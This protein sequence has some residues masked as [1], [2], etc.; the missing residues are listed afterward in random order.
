M[1]GRCETLKAHKQQL[2]ATPQKTVVIARPDLESLPG[3]HVDLAHAHQGDAFLEG[4][5]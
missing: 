4:Q 3:Q 2:E 1:S 5:S